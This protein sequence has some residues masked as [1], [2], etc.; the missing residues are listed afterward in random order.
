VACII[1]RY[2][3]SRRREPD[4][5][6]KSVDEWG[7]LSGPGSVQRVNFGQGDA[8]VNRVSGGAVCVNAWSGLKRTFRVFFS[9]GG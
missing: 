2:E 4:G 6:S 9:F 1:S 3:V 5:G 8:R 7:V